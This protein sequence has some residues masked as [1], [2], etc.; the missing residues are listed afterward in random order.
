MNYNNSRLNA[1]IRGGNGNRTT[2]A[3]CSTPIISKP[4]VT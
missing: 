4:I 3:K 2:T 1:M